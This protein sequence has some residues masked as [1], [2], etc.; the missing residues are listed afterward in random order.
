MGLIVQAEQVLEAGTGSREP[1]PH[2]QRLFGDEAEALK[3]RRMPVDELPGGGECPG[4]GEEQPD[5][6]A[7]AGNLRPV[8]PPPEG[9]YRAR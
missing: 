7:A 1:Y 2:R 5:S 6:S 9:G 4:G 3:Q 8:G